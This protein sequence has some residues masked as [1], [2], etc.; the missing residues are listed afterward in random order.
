MR[1]TSRLI[2]GAGAVLALVGSLALSTPTLAAG[3]A[4]SEDDCKAKPSGNVAEG[5]CLVVDRRKGNCGACHAIEGV[6]LAGNIAPPLNYMSQ[7]FPDRAKLRAQ[8]WDATKFNPNSSM[9]PFGRHGILSED[10]I[11]KVVDFILTL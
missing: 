2:T 6:P 4:P 3:K 7:R 9:P 10:E 8:I 5:G 11:D 1:Q